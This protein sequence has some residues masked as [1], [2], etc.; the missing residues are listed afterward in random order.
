VA[1]SYSDVSVSC[2]V[3]PGDVSARRPE[4]VEAGGLP[5][6]LPGDAAAGGLL[7]AL[8]SS[9]HFTRTSAFVY[10]YILHRKINIDIMYL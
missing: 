5:G 2:A 4:D 3:T 8:S 7:P 10:I 6:G 9:L 1:G